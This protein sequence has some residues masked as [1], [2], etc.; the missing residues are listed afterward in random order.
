MFLLQV[1]NKFFSSLSN[2]FIFLISFN[3]YGPSGTIV[4]ID[5]MCLLPLNILNDKIYFVLSLWYVCRSFLKKTFISA[6][7]TCAFRFIGLLLGTIF[8]TVYWG[9]HWFIP[10][11]RIYHLKLHLKVRVACKFFLA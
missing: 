9:L 4:N 3:R 2:I 8:S 10:R 11:L 5:V 1:S 6:Y 7:F